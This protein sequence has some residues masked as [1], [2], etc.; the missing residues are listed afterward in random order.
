MASR[1]RPTVYTENLADVICR[2][3]AAGESLNVICKT[4]KFPA[5]STVRLWAQSGVEG[6]AA[7]YARAR[8]LQADYYAEEIIKLSDTVRVGIRTEVSED[9]HGEVTTKEVTGDMVERTRLQIDARKWYASKVAPR[10][11]GDRQAELL[12][13][14]A[15]SIQLV[16]VQ[17]GAPQVDG[18][19]QVLDITSLVKQ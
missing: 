2:R 6:F 17:A 5:E 1:G 14:S 7:K 15:A 18:K 10:K 9:E 11:Y 19:T 4:D 16:V 13:S 12:G 8:E 3:L